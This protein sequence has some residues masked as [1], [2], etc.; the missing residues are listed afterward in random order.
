MNFWNCHWW[1]SEVADT[2]LLFC[3]L[4]S[5]LRNNNGHQYCIYMHVS[6]IV[7]PCSHNTLTRGVLP[8]VVQNFLNIIITNNFRT[9]TCFGNKETIILNCIKSWFFFMKITLALGCFSWTVTQWITSQ[10]NIVCFYYQIGDRSDS[11][12]YIKSKVKAA[13]EVNIQ[14]FSEY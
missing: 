8:Y 3:R 9:C 10:F 4:Y 13:E 2:Y 7:K 11:T 6:C 14:L 1:S 5:W 12:V